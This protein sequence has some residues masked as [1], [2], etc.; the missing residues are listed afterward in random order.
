MEQAVISSKGRTS[1]GGV[2]SIDIKALEKAEKE[3]VKRNRDWTEDEI[4]V[5]KRFYGKV[6][7]QTLAQQLKRTAT[8]VRQCYSREVVRA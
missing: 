7:I 5:I 4:K 3:Y 8:S 2:V 6:H 1:Y